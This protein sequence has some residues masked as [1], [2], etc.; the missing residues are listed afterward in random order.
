LVAAQLNAVLIWC[1][2]IMHMA[3]AIGDRT[4]VGACKAIENKTKDFVLLLYIILDL[5]K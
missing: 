4:N 2:H 5:Y 1:L 3:I